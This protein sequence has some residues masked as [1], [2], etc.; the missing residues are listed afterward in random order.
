M[1]QED[2]IKLHASRVETYLKTS[3]YPTDD[4]FMV[5]DYLGLHLSKPHL[6]P[7]VLP[8][9][10]CE[11]LDTWSAPAVMSYFS[12]IWSQ[13]SFDKAKLNNK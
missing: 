2:Y 5:K 6:L 1:M 13:R 9:P 11:I 8:T 4:I 7:P 10:D 3:A 12:W